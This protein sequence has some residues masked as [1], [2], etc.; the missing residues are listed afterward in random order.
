MV[1]FEQYPERFRAEIDSIV[2]LGIECRIEEELKAKGI[3]RLHLKINP[4]NE[5]VLPNADEPIDLVVVYPDYFPLFRPEVYAYGVDLPR[6]QHPARH[7]LCLIPRG[8]ENW[9]P[10]QRVGEFLRSRL[11]LVFEKG[12]IIDQE[13]IANDSTEQAEPVS[14]YYS[15][16]AQILFDPTGIE[17]IEKKA[18]GLLGY[19]RLG[20]PK[21]A[22]FPSSMAVRKTLDK[23]KKEIH[24][25][26]PSIAR[27]F[28][29]KE[30]TGV[31]Y[32]APEPPPFDALKV[33]HWLKDGIRLSGQQ[34]DFPVNNIKHINGTFKR[35]TGICFPEETEP[36]V[37]GNGWL[38]FVEGEAPPPPNEEKPELGKKNV[39]SFYFAKPGYI[40]RDA[41]GYR[42]PRISALDSHTVTLI[43]LGALG[44][45]AAIELAR[46][47]VKELR[48][49]DF[50]IVDPPTTIRWG[51]GL[52]AAGEFKG[53]A[54]K[55][56]IEKNYPACTVKT[57]N[58]RI[59]SINIEGQGEMLLNR[60]SEQDVIATALEGTSLLIDATAEEGINHLFSREC[61]KRGLPYVIMYGTPGAWG[62]LVLRVVPGKT[63]G[64]WFCMKH[65]QNDNQDLVPPVDDDGT[66]QPPGCGDLTFT[67]ASF[68]LQQV[69][70]ACVRMAVSTLT[71]PSD[72]GYQELPWDWAVLKLVDEHGN[73][74]IPTWNPQ[75]LKR[76][77]KC[78][79]C[80]S[81]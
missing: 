50:D 20:V 55:S 45:F 74:S 73:P 57:W 38:F 76:H 66:I 58:R 51:L 30:M 37:T 72:G 41:M 78:P 70:L 5:N 48:L 62:G 60:E 32:Q 75:I 4:H 2:Q 64:C 14:D 59:G 47:G 34:A 61:D 18:F 29:D 43:G 8:T 42:V 79:Y 67:G 52:S 49:I 53:N 81:Y 16:G 24:S 44:S 69:S 7:N 71:S 25:I 63:E 28:D 33:V 36:G 46:S 17:L 6:H 3:I 31:L 35:V 54:V 68:D 22:A 15:A 65:W 21:N 77:P 27:L 39:P 23:S 11:P 26:W 1:W 40:N 10:T 13:I 19:M 80:V 56:F 12:R 9:E